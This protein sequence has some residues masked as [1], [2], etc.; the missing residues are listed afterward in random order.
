VAAPEPRRAR[1]RG[2]TPARRATTRGRAVPTDRASRRRAAAARRN[3]LFVGA[4]VAVSGAVLLAWFPGTS[5]L[6]ERHALDAAAAQL[7]QLRRENRALQHQAK[8]LQTPSSLARVAEQQFDLAPH[9]AQAYQVL[10]KSG[11]AGSPVLSTTLG[12]GATARRARSEANATAG[13]S[14]FFGRVLQTL[15]FW[16]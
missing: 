5:L 8:Q 16:R 4:A 11:S 12:T 3:R 6:N 14:S 13:P 7:G 1:A 2:G 9:G 15:E 10:P